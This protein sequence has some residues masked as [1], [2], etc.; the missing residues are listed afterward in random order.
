MVQ[1]NVP[2]SIDSTEAHLKKVKADFDLQLRDAQDKLSQV[3][4]E[5]KLKE[6]NADEVRVCLVPVRWTCYGHAIDV[7]VCVYVC[8]CEHRT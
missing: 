5:E 7:C 2:I 1:T 8:V 6:E 3:V 4:G